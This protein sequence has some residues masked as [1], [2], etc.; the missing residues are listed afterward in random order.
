MFAI[1]RSSLRN[2]QIEK[3]LN[4]KIMTVFEGYC[5]KK[6]KL[7]CTEVTFNQNYKIILDFFIEL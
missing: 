4:Q 7:R 3:E 1:F 2:I 5:L 6:F